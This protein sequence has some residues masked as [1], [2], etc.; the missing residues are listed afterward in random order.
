MFYLYIIFDKNFYLDKYVWVYSKMFSYKLL[1]SVQVVSVP[2][3]NE[4]LTH[5]NDTLKKKL[6]LCGQESWLLI[7]LHLSFGYWCNS[8][9]KLWK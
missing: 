6:P 3:Y 1:E 9:N 5:F 7:L 2:L 4:Q 8:V